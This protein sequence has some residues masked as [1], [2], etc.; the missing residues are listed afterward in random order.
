MIGTE[1]IDIVDQYVMV[2]DYWKFICVRNQVNNSRQ[3]NSVIWRHG[4]MVAAVERTTL[5]YQKIGSITERDHSSVTHAVNVHEANHSYD[6]DYKQAYDMMS[7]DLNNLMGDYH[8]KVEETMNRR[9]VDLHGNQAMQN[10]VERYNRRIT[11]IE[12]NHQDELIKK[13]HVIN[14]LAKQLKAYEA[15]NNALNKEILR[16]KNLL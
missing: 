9:V 6:K 16:V 2:K 12:R 7:Y 15:R 3:R 4:F 1:V 5:T 13:D 11:K 14:S 8:K 10:I